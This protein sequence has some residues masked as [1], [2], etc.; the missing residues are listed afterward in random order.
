MG[1]R[2]KEIKKQLL[3]LEKRKAK[4]EEQ[5]SK[6]LDALNKLNKRIETIEEEIEKAVKEKMEKECEE[7]NMCQMNRML[8]HQEN[9]EILRCLYEQYLRNK[10]EQYKKCE[11]RKR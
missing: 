10:V 9:T 6:I 1:D 3:C 7:R 11:N 4:L 5:E 2:V 8:K